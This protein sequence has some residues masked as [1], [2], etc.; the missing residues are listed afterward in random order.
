M[1]IENDFDFNVD[2]TMDE[3][4]EMYEKIPNKEEKS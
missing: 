3:I 1:N 4:V 2:L